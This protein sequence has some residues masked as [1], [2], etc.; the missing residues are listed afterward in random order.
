MIIPRRYHALAIVA[1]AAAT[2]VWSC[3]INFPSETVT[4]EPKLAPRIEA[5]RLPA[6]G[7]LASFPAEISS[8]RT[9]SQVQPVTYIQDGSGSSGSGAAQPFQPATTSFQPNDFQNPLSR[10][11]PGPSAKPSSGQMAGAKQSH[12]PALRSNREL[13]QRLQESKILEQPLLG[14]SEE[15]IHILESLPP[16]C[17]ADLPGLQ[18]MANPHRPLTEEER[19]QVAGIA[20]VIASTESTSQ[21]PSHSTANQ[22]AAFQSP[23]NPQQETIRPVQHLSAS[24]PAQY[25]IGVNS[26]LT[27][28]N[29]PRSSSDSIDQ[30]LNRAQHADAPR[31]ASNSSPGTMPNPHAGVRDLATAMA[32]NDPNAPDPHAAIY[33]RDAFP[34]AVQC[35]ECHQ[36]IFDEWASSSHAYA[37]ISP[38]F[39]VF[40]DTINKLTQG[41]I[42]YFC[43]RCHAP[44]ATTMGLRRD[45]PIWDGPRVFREGVTCVACHRVK[46][47][48]GKTNGE[49]RIEPGDITQPVYGSADGTGVEV[50][51]KYGSYFKVKTDPND[52]SPGQLIHKRGI[53]FE[54]LGKSTFCMSCHQVAVQPG[55]KLEVVWDQY[56][57]SPARR[58]GV[59]CQDCHMGKVPG[60][61]GGY[62]VGPAAV[63]NDKVVNPE[64]K[65][66]NHAFYGPGYSIAHPGIFPH[67]KEADRWTVNQWLTFDWRAGWGTDEF[68]DALDEGSFQAY[69]PPEW[70]E[71]DDRYDAREIV[72]DNL[73]E[74]AYKK[75]LRRQV[76]ENGS[77]LDGPF[78]K[79]QPA[80]GAPL[81]FH[82]CLTNLNSGHNMPSGSLGAQPQLWMNAVLIGPDGNRIWETGYVDSNGDLA[83][84]HSLDVL[85]RRIPFDDQLF[86]LQTK[87]LTT[88]VKGTDREMY[89]PI[90]FDIDQLPFIRPAAQPVTVI[91]H[92]PFIRMEAHS[93]PPLGSKKAKF[94]VP[95]RLLQQPGTYRLSVRMRSRAEPIYFMRFCNSTAEMERMM[96]EWIADFHTSSVVFEVR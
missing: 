24:A 88:N 9:D 80:V 89:L 93:I 34:S 46:V 77:K 44:V 3:V 28:A 49:R 17:G 74:L 92:P 65:H 53:Q 83:D 38:M 36:Q 59:T 68:E 61:D 41:T 54:E 19:T 20:A 71:V 35:G 2:V 26:F 6:S 86:N 52:K 16:A 45:Q 21:S 50:A 30:Y 5:Q 22:T 51:T 87:F 42:G 81:K 11:H 67:N 57:A 72:D 37:S 47:P 43:L 75:D 4:P 63:V 10:L 32:S 12:R 85:A 66:S 95:S 78:F 90:N 31:V 56:R 8:Q 58:E 7:L 27:N 18:Q 39:H 48:Y 60:V 62:S 70:T 79:G 13:V 94:V 73:K 55:I 84:N 33:S 64:R 40:E 14:L 15:D 25:P 91:N 69:F 1:L 76:L 82:Y 23:Q 96:N 29:R